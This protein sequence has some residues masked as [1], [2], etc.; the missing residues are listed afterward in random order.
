MRLVKGND[1]FVT[2]NTTV[3]RAFKNNGWTE[4]EEKP[5]PQPEPKKKATKK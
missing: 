2:D 5:A 4:Q 3:I 1:V